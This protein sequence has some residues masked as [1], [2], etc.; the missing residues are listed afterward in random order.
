MFN[1]NYKRKDKTHI[2]LRM[3]VP[4]VDFSQYETYVSLAQKD[5]TA[6]NLFVHH[7]IN[8]NNIINSVHPIKRKCSIYFIEGTLLFH[9]ES[10]A[11]R[12]DCC[13]DSTD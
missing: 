9:L 2:V 11:K 7:R 12:S 1:F 10:I 5:K 6:E 13:C 3:S 8:P 4:H